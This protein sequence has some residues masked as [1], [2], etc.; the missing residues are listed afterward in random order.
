MK[1]ITVNKVTYEVTGRT[2]VEEYRAQG[3]VNLAA[4]ME[5]SGRVADITTKRPR[6]RKGYLFT[7]YK[8]GHYEFLV[9]V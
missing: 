8:N 1:T 3:L 6:G 2:T 9:S 5:K 7:E 4:L